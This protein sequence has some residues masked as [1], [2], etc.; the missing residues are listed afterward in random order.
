MNTHNLDAQKLSVRKIF[1]ALFNKRDYQLADQLFDPRL[2]CNINDYPIK[3][4]RDFVRLVNRFNLSFANTHAEL[5]S[6]FCE[7]DMVGTHWKMVLLPD[8][9]TPVLTAK[10]ITIFK[11][12]TEKVVQLDQFWNFGKR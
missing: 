3:N 10:G 8:K 6:I 4:R 12:R 9:D 11:F 2:H 7:G 5:I 1:Y